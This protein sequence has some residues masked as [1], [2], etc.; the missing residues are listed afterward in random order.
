MRRPGHPHRVSGFGLRP[1]SAFGLRVSGFGSTLLCGLVLALALS[2]T[3]FGPAPPVT[4]NQTRRWPQEMNWGILSLLAVVAVVLGGVAAFFVYL[5]R[6]PQRRCSH[7]TGDRERAVLGRSH[8]QSPG[9]S[10]ESDRCARGGS[11]S[12]TVVLAWL[13]QIL[14]D[15]PLDL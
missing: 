5:A 1:S 4:A 7:N 10:W 15:Q 2:P 9:N 8:L 3:H 13:R 14:L 6:D 12:D 11:P